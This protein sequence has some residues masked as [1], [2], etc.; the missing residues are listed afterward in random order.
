MLLARWMVSQQAGR[1]TR[2]TAG[3]PDAARS[4][5]GE[6]G[7]LV[8]SAVW[9]G[10]AVARCDPAGM[11]PLRGGSYAPTEMPIRRPMPKVSA[12]AARPKST[13]RV[14]E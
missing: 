5:D 8:A 14:P 4:L 3:F 9:Q 1:S 11:D 10:R 2:Q 7:A 13:C 12:A 6:P